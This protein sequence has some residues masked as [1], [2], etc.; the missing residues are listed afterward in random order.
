MH[1]KQVPKM[2]NLGYWFVKNLSISLAYKKCTYTDD[3]RASEI[4]DNTIYG[5]FY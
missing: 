4:E 1:P 2:T 3:P 5:G